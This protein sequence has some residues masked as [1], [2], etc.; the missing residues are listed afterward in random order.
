MTQPNDNSSI[1]ADAAPPT[2]IDEDH[3]D[4]DAIRRQVRAQTFV[5]FFLALSHT[6]PGQVEFYFSDENLPTDLHLLKCCG[7]RENLPVSISLICGFK[8]MR[9]YKPKKLVVAALRKSLVLEVVENGK[10]IKRRRPMQGTCIL[11]PDFFDADDGIAHDPRVCRQPA[12]YPVP[13]LPQNKVEY[14]KGISKNMLKPTGFEK[15]YIEPMPTPQEAAEEEAMYDPEK[16]F[17]ERIEIAI[18]RFK[19]K[20]RM[21]E[22]YAHVFNKL[23]RF[24]GVESGPRMNQGLSRQEMASMDAEEVAKALAIH[25]VPWSRAD[26]K[27]WVVDFY[28]VAKAFLSSWYPA[29]YG[30]TPQGIKNACQVLRSFYKYLLYHDVCPEYKEDLIRARDLCDQAEQELPKVVAAGLALPGDFN[31]SASVIFGGAHAGQYTGDQPWALKLQAEGVDIAEIGIRKEEAKIKFKAGVF[32]MGTDGQ[33]DKLEGGTLIAVGKEQVGLEVIG[34]SLPDENTKLAYEQTGDWGLELSKLEPLGK[35][36]CK[37]WIMDDCDEWDLPN[38]PGK[39]PQGKPYRTSD[40]KTY[41]FW[42]EA[43]V[44]EECFLGMKLDA[45]VLT[46][47]DGLAILDDVKE[48]MCNFF[49]WLPN[50][51]WMERK[52]KEVRWLSK[53]LGVDDEEDQANGKNNEGEGKGKDDDDFDDE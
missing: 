20:R 22:M 51:L 19:Q 7:G 27:Q 40:V 8:K 34:I 25:N 50:E 6:D 37:T 31:K 3:P 35:L 16:S 47:T 9:G 39:Y 33:A 41:E 42:V 4:G 17:I 29:H 14:P 52:P 32:I 12:V 38:A 53:G 36:I 23:M 5:F 26:T 49:T 43:S 10:K 2:A 24:S 13:L 46:L 21:H 44:L 1:T 45:S 15:T 11:D 18:Q 28:G 48:S 30:M